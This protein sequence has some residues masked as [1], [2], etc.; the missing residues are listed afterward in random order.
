MVPSS[1]VSFFALHALV[2]HQR[3]KLHEIWH[4]YLTIE[5]YN[6]ECGVSASPNFIKRAGERGLK[7]G[8]RIFRWVAW[9]ECD[10]DKM[11]HLKDIH[12]ISIMK[13]LVTYFMKA[14]PPSIPIVPQ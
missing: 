3:S 6:V 7:N 5:E 8:R 12:R 2:A 11:C 13:K 1:W 4:P 14:T 10:K 9:R